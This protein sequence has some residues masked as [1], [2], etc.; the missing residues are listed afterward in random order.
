MGFTPT[1]GLVMSARAG[2]LDPGVLAYLVQ[3]GRVR[4]EDLGTL[5]NQRSG[6]LAVADGSTGDMRELLV[7]ESSD[8]AAAEAIALFCYQARKFLAALTATLGGLE[9]L[10]FTGGIGE[11]AASIRARICEGF[12]YLGIQLDAARNGAPAPVISVDGSP[13]TV[14]VMTTDEDRVIAEHTLALLG[15]QGGFSV[16]L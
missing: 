9:T 8:R 12:Q 10:V 6:L 15:E 11:H 14:R 2:D 13:V 7:R 3:T 16:S 1:G 5:V 4:A